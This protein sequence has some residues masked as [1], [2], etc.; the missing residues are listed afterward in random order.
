MMIRVTAPIVALAMGV[1]LCACGSAAPAASPAFE[2]TSASGAAASPVAVSPQPGTPDASP[3]T[4]ISFLGPHGTHVA[5]VHVVGSHSGAHAGVL[6]AYSTGT[7]ESFLPAHRFA[8]GERVKVSAR[9][10]VGT[11]SYAASTSF[12]VAHQASVSQ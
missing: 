9:V 1:G 8:T 11:T 12:T 5:E 6:R 2:D 3:S 7:G 10:T 4:Q